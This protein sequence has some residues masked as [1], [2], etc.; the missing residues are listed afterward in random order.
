MLLDGQQKISELL[1]PALI[2]VPGNPTSAIFLDGF[3][4]CKE[5][6]PV[7]LALMSRMHL[8]GLSNQAAL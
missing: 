2:L 3:E 4:W 7:H 6:K 8:Q 1:D 5:G